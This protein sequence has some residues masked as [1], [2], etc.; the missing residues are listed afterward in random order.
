MV[1]EAAPVCGV[2]QRRTHAPHDIPC[3]NTTGTRTVSVLAAL[4]VLDV[5]GVTG[6]GKVDTLDTVSAITS[7]TN[8]ETIETTPPIAI[9]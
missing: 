7:N 6:S 1:G 5:D 3:H 8:H 2:Q 4:P 9:W